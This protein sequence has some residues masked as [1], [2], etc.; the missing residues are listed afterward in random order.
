MKSHNE[1]DIVLDK[2][3]DL[4]EALAYGG[5]DFFL[6]ETNSLNIYDEKVLKLL[7]NLNKLAEDN[8]EIANAINSIAKGDLNCKLSNNKNIVAQNLKTLQMRLK[9]L[10]YKTK[11]IASGDYEQHLDFLGELS[12]SFNFMLEKL[13]T[14]I[15]T[16]EEQ[17]S[18][19]KKYQDQKFDIIINN[20]KEGIFILDVN[21]NIETYNQAALNLLRINDY[22]LV[23][24]NIED[25][26]PG[27]KNHL[28]TILSNNELYEIKLEKTIELSQL[29]KVDIRID[30]NKVFTDHKK[31]IILIITDISEFKEVQRLK[32]QFLAVVSHELR[33]PVT[34]INGYLDLI[35]SGICGTIDDDIKVMIEKSRL[36]CSRLNSIINDLLDIEKFESEKIAFNM[37]KHKCIDIVNEIIKINQD[38]IEKNNMSVLL[39]NNLKENILIYIDGNRLTQAVTNLITNA[40]KNAPEYTPIEFH[41]KRN[42]NTL[43]I[44][45]EDHGCGI[46]DEIKNKVFDK[47]I[48]ADSSDSRS[49][50]GGVGL[51]LSIAKNIIEKMNGEIS[52]ETEVN[53]GTTFY[54]KLPIYQ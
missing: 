34:I 6:I 37:Q 48:Q 21:N 1:L 2:I 46:S 13:K 30:I 11:M 43:I 23:N 44:A 20:M 22:D 40:I 5:K 28:A 45:V 52:F 33:T 41:L 7:N 27:I 54:I 12:D 18:Q 17:S 29:E 42:Q 3:N 39:H 4:L 51:G 50:K 15:A 49:T 38:L 16:I 25:F 19:I 9:H 26:L 36:N 10:V 31:R 32:D 24:K 47:F 14:S 53:K 8:I 35:A